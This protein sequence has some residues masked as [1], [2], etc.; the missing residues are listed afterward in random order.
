MRAI[1]LL[2]ALLALRR[3]LF[4]P[5]GYIASS[6]HSHEDQLREK[7]LDGLL[8]ANGFNVLSVKPTGLPLSAIG[9]HGLLAKQIRALGGLLMKIWPTMFGYQ[10]ILEASFSDDFVPER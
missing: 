8:E 9:V 4:I 3:D 10:F 1:I 5:Q 7:R 2:R 6:C